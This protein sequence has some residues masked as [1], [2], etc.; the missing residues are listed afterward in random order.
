MLSIPSSLLDNI[1]ITITITIPITIGESLSM[2]ERRVRIRNVLVVVPIGISYSKDWWSHINLPM[3]KRSV[4]QYELTAV[5]GG[6]SYSF[7]TKRFKGKT[8]IILI[9]LAN[10]EIYNPILPGSFYMST[11]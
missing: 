1:I 9:L 2:S 8:R 10:L 7:S 3:V 5:A 11:K 6:S 4:S